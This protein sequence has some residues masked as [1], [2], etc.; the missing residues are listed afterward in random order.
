MK[1]IN[2]TYA[3]CID[4]IDKRYEEIVTTN[5]LKTGE[6][7]PVITIKVPKGKKIKIVGITDPVLED[8]NDANTLVTRLSDRD[9]NAIDFMTKVVITH[10][11]SDG[12]VTISKLFYCDINMITTSTLYKDP[13][14]TNGTTFYRLKTDLEWYIFKDTIILNE[15]EKLV[16]S[17]I[18]PNMNIEK[19]KFAICANIENI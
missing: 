11:K 15:D 7:G 18:S 14:L 3:I 4:E 16:I 10:E 1:N 13:D 9:D 12:T 5:N 6:T 8:K 2:E 17:A 19:I